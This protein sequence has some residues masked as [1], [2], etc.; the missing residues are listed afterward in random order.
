M[1]LRI[2]R[3]VG[4]GHDT[5]PLVYR[6][7]LCLSLFLLTCTLTLPEAGYSAYETLLELHS[8][9]MEPSPSPTE[10]ARRML[11]QSVAFALRDIFVSLA[12]P[13]AYVALWPAYRAAVCRASDETTAG[14]TGKPLRPANRAPV[15]TARGAARCAATRA[16]DR[17]PAVNYNVEYTS[18]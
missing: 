7:R 14:V 2:S 11:A 12:K 17:G 13:L 8:G 15:R 9:G 6:Y 18:I 10:V 3:I 16:P 4:P 1:T 5:S